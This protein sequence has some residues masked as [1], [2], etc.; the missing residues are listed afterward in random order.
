MRVTEDIKYIGVND[1]STALFESLYKIPN[2]ISYN[3]Y[4]IMDE[5]IAVFDTV[6]AAF[7]KEWLAKLE[8]ALG[9]RCPDYLI[10]Q[11]M[12]PDHSASI[13]HFIEAYPHATIVASEKA[14]V[15]MKNFFG[16]DFAARRIV[17]GDGDK[18]ALGKHKLIFLEAPMVH[19]PEVIMTYEVTDKILFSADA[20]GKFGA[21][22]VHDNWVDEARRYYIGIV[23]KY[24]LFVQKVLDKLNG[25]PVRVICPLHGVVL[26]EDIQKYIT[27]YDMWSSYRPEEE[28]VLIAYASIYGNTKQAAVLLERELKKRGMAVKLMDLARCDRAEAIAQAFRY[29]KL[30]L[31]CSTYNAELFP[32]MREYIDCLKER[33]YSNR[34]VAFIENGSWAIIAA[35]LMK[36]RLENCRNLTFAET[37]V[38]ITSS[39]SEESRKQIE[40]LAQ[41]LVQ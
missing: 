35:K 16:T 26:K 40:K 25:L 18:L 14:F 34:T 19:W 37:V 15:M 3:S 32:A 24:G 33:F 27:L 7:G 39:V 8:N 36:E 31:A 12:E 41:E 38:R 11:H 30:V 23:G 9:G 20:F 5:K 17:V 13:M 2:G 4:V 21:T 28:G 10:V 22:D 6:D 29:S 1:H